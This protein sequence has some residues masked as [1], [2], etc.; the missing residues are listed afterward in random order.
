MA[1]AAEQKNPL[2]EGLTL[3]RTPDPFA[4]VIFGASGDLT[5][6]KLMPAMYALATRRLL[7]SRYAIVGCRPHR[8]KRRIVSART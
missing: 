6:K 2:E 5:H 1:A 8:G 3:R 4:L 7:P